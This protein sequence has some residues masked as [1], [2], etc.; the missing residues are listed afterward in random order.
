MALLRGV[1][2]VGMPALKTLKGLNYDGR[3]QDY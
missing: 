2:L 1:H 3:Q